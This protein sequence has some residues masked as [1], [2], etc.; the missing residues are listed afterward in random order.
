MTSEKLAEQFHDAY[1]ELAPA[2]SY[3]T[4][5][6]SAVPWKDVPEQNKHLMVAVAERV[7]VP[8]IKQARAEVLGACIKAV[9][10]TLCPA[11]NSI[12]PGLIHVADYVEETLRNLQPAAKHLEALLRE[13]RD[14]TEARLLCGNAEC[15]KRHLRIEWSEEERV[16]LGCLRDALEYQSGLKDGELKGRLCALRENPGLCN[17]DTDN[18]ERHVRLC[19]YHQEIHELEKARAEGEG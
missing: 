13:E 7:M 6:A 9:N 4:R 15:P 8:A 17:G 12:G 14:G 11:L 10:A 3:K 18:P 1:E 16:C 19:K 2:F 5:K